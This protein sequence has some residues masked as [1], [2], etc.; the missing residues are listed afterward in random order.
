[1]TAV[2]RTSIASPSLGEMGLELDVF[3]ENR[4]YAKDT[5]LRLESVKNELP[6]N[7]AFR[8]IFDMVRAQVIDQV[9][10]GENQDDVDFEELLKFK[11]PNDTELD[12]EVFRPSK[13]KWCSPELFEKRTQL[14]I[15]RTLRNLKQLRR[16]YGTYQLQELEEQLN[17]YLSMGMSPAVLRQKLLH[18]SRSNN[19]SIYL[20][21]KQDFLDQWKE[22]QEAQHGQ[23]E[24]TPL[25]EADLSETMKALF[26][27]KSLIDQKPQVLRFTDYKF[28]R[29]F[30]A[31]LHPAMS[32]MGLDFW[33]TEE[34]LEQFH[35]L[36]VAIRRKYQVQ[37]PFHVFRFEN[38]FTYFICGF[39]D[40]AVAES[41]TEDKNTAPV[42]AKI[43]M[44]QSNKVYRELHSH[45]S[46]NQTLYFNCLKEA[47]LPFVEQL[48]KRLKIDLSPSFI[49]FFRV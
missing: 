6:D 25:V 30:N 45:D 41:I 3:E 9:Y 20:Q 22:S 44:R 21:L 8:P 47:M 15:G 40:E 26:Q 33:K 13:P 49:D 28:F 18:V 31:T 19:F 39:A 17:S 7:D 2:S 37:S 12:Y 1:M 29:P 24:K 10:Q 11:G 27:Q 16:A 32:S 23:Q 48:N 36:I 42:H 34:N 5:L 38:S 43:I 14:R 4:F 35:Q 46:H